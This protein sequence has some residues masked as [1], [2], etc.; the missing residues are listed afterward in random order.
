[1]IFGIMPTIKVKDSTKERLKLFGKFGMTYDEVV[2]D[3]LDQLEEA[4]DEEIGEDDDD[5]DDEE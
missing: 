2:N 1:M 5:D 3:A 4:I